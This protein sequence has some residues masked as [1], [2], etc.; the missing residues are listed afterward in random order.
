MFCNNGNTLVGSGASYIKNIGTTNHKWKNQIDPINGCFHA[1]NM[2]CNF[3]WKEYL[4][5]LVF[6]GSQSIV[7]LPAEVS[8]N[9][10]FVASSELKCLREFCVFCARKHSKYYFSVARQ[11]RKILMQ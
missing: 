11:K 8:H 5:M 7:D 3:S 10:Y 6:D 2:Y 9:I 4:K 1:I